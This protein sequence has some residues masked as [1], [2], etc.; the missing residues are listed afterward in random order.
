MLSMF[1]DMQGAH[2]TSSLDS[3]L[4]LLGSDG[5]AQRI[6]SVFVIG[7]GQ[8]YSEALASPLCSAVHLT[9][10]WRCSHERVPQ[11]MP[12]VSTSSPC[13]GATTALL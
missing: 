4:A 12:P 2:L 6:E 13:V 9:Q 11:G 7:G 10:V 5:F 8:I 1:P 3:A